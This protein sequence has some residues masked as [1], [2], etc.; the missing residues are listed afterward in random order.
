VP[1]GGIDTRIASLSDI[2]PTILDLAGLPPER[3]WQGRTLLAPTARQRVYVFAT[4][5]DYVL[6]YRE[7]DSKTVI[8]LTTGSNVR[9]DLRR[10]PGER[11]P[12]TLGPDAARGGAAYCRVGCLSGRAVS[13]RGALTVAISQCPDGSAKVSGIHPLTMPPSIGSGVPTM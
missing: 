5:R 1:A 3:S 4:S 13:P 11:H 10:D 6:G 9:Y 8:D 12:L 2:A 7:G